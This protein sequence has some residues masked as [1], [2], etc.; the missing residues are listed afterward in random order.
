MIII[1]AIL[2]FALGLRLGISLKITG[3]R[4]EDKDAYYLLAKKIAESGAYLGADNKYTAYRPVLYPLV[5][6]GVIKICGEGAASIY[7]L[8]ALLGCSSVLLIYIIVKMIL[9]H[10]AAIL[11]A[12]AAAVEPFL[13]LISAEVMGEAL[14][15]FLLL[16]LILL[17]ISMKKLSKTKTVIT[18]IVMALLAL[19]RPEGILFIIQA[20]V[21]FITL[22][23]S[24]KQKITSLLVF[25]CIFLAVYSP[26][27]FRN[28]LRFGAF[29][30]F[31]THGGYTLYLGN[32]ENIYN[33]ESRGKIWE[34]DN[35]DRWT[36]ANVEGTAHMSELERDAYYYKMA[37]EFISADAGIFVHLLW[38]KFMRFW[39]LYPHNVSEIM[40]AIS[41][42]YMSFLYILS[43][44]G[45]VFLF[46]NK[47]ELFILI[48][49]IV[50][51][52]GIHM[53]YWSQIRFRVPLHPIFIVLSMCFIFRKNLAKKVPDGTSQETK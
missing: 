44:M 43:A 21:V 17:F 22:N 38:L 19:C 25:A 14:F 26:W 4:I 1:S 13:V 41:I 29:V 7:F 18:A 9:G 33:A 36:R 23:V 40:K 34:D 10:R 39:R 48:M 8:N 27:V 24:F 15:V 28:Y 46:K 16:F 52:C 11:A 6:A 50:L 32:N 30:P 31:T 5:L 3:G 12:L 45:A 2:I 42:I 37:T 53:V 51:L 35:F 49:P 20:V 47:R